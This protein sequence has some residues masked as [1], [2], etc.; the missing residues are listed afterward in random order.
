MYLLTLQY[1]TKKLHRW[2]NAKKVNN[3]NNTR[4]FEMSVWVASMPYLYTNS[5]Q[6][7]TRSVKLINIPQ[8][9]L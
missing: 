7:Y 4:D 9:L 8:L 5:Y 1:Q 6:Y 3:I 2:Y